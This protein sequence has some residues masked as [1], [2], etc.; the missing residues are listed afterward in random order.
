MKFKL[1]VI[2]SLFIFT[3]TSCES[4]KTETG[5]IFIPAGIVDAG[6]NKGLSSEKPVKRYSVDSF[7]MSEHPITVG[8][9]REFIKASNYI[10]EAERFGNSGVFSFSKRR[11]Y[12]QDG[13]YWEY[14]AGPNKEK[15]R[16]DHPVTQVSWNDAV[17]Y[18]TWKGERLPT[19]VEWEH[20]AR[21]G[22]NSR[23][24]Y[25]WGNE[26]EVKGK[27]QANVWQGKFPF[28]NTNEDGFLMTS[29][30]KH[31]P[32]TSLGLYDMAG[33]VWEWTDS[34]YR[35][36]N[37]ELMKTIKGGSFLCEP[38]FCHGYRVSSRMGTT[39]ETSLMHTGFRTVKN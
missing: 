21:N 14:P 11:W 22:N 39:P 31:F 7:Y 35:E 10:T 13:A 26:I 30:V 12:M 20:A 25:S 4:H 36:E 34:E 15:A 1:I 8:Q 9:F 18:A 17:A 23:H 28:K 29:P 38:D 32:K 37:N 5:Y 27:H 19:E 2:V 16:D 3:L 24:I 33:N 6:S